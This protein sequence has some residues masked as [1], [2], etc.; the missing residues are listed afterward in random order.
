MQQADDS[1]RAALNLMEDAIQARQAL[2]QLNVDLRESERRFR[3][4]IDALPAAVYTTD[5]QGRLTHFNPA[6]RLL[7]GRTPQIGTDE[8]CVTWKLYHA[9]GT[10]LPYDEYPLAVAIKEGRPISGLEV[11]AERPDGTRVWGESY[12]TPLRDSAGQIVGGINMVID[13][14]DRKQTEAALMRWKHV[15]DQAGW[16]VA[17]VNEGDD[18]F[19]DVNP[20]FAK[21]H[22]YAVKDLLGTTLADT[23][24]P[25]ARAELAGHVLAV[26]MIGDIEYESIHIRKD[27][28][29]FPCLTHATAFKDDNGKVSF[30]AATFQDLTVTRATERA[31][32]E[33]EERF[34][35]L[36]DNMSQF[37][38]MADAQG[39]IFWFNQRWYDYT[40]TTLEEMVGWG[41]K[42][43]HHPDHVERVVKRIQQSW[44]TGEVWEDTFPLRGKDGTYRWFLSRALPICDAQNKVIRWF[45]THTDVTEQREMAEALRQNAIA[46]TESDRR[47]NEFL[48]MLAHELRNPLAPIRNGLQIIRLSGGN[49]QV[50]AE[51]SEMMERQIGHMVRL[52]DDLLDVSRI[53]RGKIELR[54]E[55]V[56]LT[57]LVE[58]AV[59]GSRPTIDCA[60]HDLI[61]SL[62]P[63]KLYLKADPIR[64][65]QVVGNLLNNACKFTPH[66][67][68]IWLNVEY[69]NQ[70]AVIRVRDNGI[71]I[72]TNHIPQIFDMFMQIDTT[73]GRSVSGLGIGLTLVK[74]I[75]EM[76]SGSVEVY[77]AGM[78][79]GSEFVV[80]L[81]VNQDMAEPPPPEPAATKPTT[82]TNR[83]ILVVDDNCD[84]ATSLAMLLKLSGNETRTAFDGLEAIAEAETFMP[85][86]VLLDIGMP[87]LDGYET[88][89]R[90]R[91]QSWGKHIRMVALT[92]WGQ[93]A[94]RQKSKDAGFNDHMVKP[95]DLAALKQL[96]AETP[97]MMDTNDEQPKR[98]DS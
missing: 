51:S 90:I 5:A 91:A 4:I 65:A 85:N 75:V 42:S 38:W 82:P 21:M 88:C 39:W 22:G 89:R 92:G 84:S 58:H 94:D 71:G 18:T 76:H 54:H 2:E 55:R 73:L 44:D 81:P 28:T 64:L 16:A 24:A 60:R 20:A 29:R 69:E 27:G 59:E 96:L 48:A 34:R 50:V 98:S 93:E 53:S 26:H 83:R 49:E 87:K 45:G 78:G 9:E 32:R 3:E 61:L 11:I 14:T 66:N 95:I 70:Q 1:R 72:T 37:A 47:K 79:L 77:S 13:I 74:N 46:M 25:E 56:E 57:S 17:I 12:P 68:R 86:V 23:F 8:W 67:G 19:R 41:W 35:M 40:G 36:A 33:S 7:A 63:Q 6:A 15:F 97:P 62:P 10:P 30:R 31:L 80:R 52:V 43:V